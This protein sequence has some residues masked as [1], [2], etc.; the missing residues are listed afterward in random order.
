MDLP[1]EIQVQ[2][3]SNIIDPFTIHRIVKVCRLWKEIIE[4]LENEKGL[5]F[6]TIKALKRLMCVESLNES[7][8][9]QQ[10]ENRGFHR[11]FKEGKD[12]GQLT[13][14]FSRH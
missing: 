4:F 1:V 6:R 3:L 8:A 10:E 14:S 5:R 11:K 7:V 12:Q 9:I 13:F 2:I